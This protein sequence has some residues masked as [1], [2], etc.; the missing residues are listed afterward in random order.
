MDEQVAGIFSGIG[1]LGLFNGLDNGFNGGITV[2]VNG[3]LQPGPVIGIHFFIQGLLAH[4]GLADM[5]LFH[6]VMVGSRE[7]SGMA[8][9]GA[10]LEELHRSQSHAICAK[11]AA[12]TQPVVL[13]I[14]IIHQGKIGPQPQIL[15]SGQFPIRPDHQGAG[16]FHTDGRIMDGC[17]P[18]FIGQ[19]SP[20]SDQGLDLVQFRLGK[21]PHDGKQGGLL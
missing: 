6:P 21:Q 10:V 18:A 1:G 5:A 8:L 19:G 11:A 17:H 12:Q 14:K 3:N 16:P 13:V 4:D 15:F 20:P 9:D 2:A 7:P